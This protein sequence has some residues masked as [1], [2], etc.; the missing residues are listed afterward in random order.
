M[1]GVARVAVNLR[2]VPREAVARGDVLL[3]PGRWLRAAELDVRLAGVRDPGTHRDV[4]LLDDLPEQLTLHIGSA[5]RRAV[6]YTHLRA[7]ET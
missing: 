7:H 1:A 2:G 5:A 4:P 6:S 3:T